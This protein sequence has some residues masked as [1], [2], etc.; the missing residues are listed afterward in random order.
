MGKIDIIPV[1]LYYEII[2]YN[3]SILCK[4]FLLNKHYHDMLSNKIITQY[5]TCCRYIADTVYSKYYQSIVCLKITLTTKKMVDDLVNSKFMS[6]CSDLRDIEMNQWD[7][8]EGSELLV[9]K[10]LRMKKI[11]SIAFECMCFY[12]MSLINFGNF[13]KL[14][15]FEYTSCNFITND[16]L[17]NLPAVE[18]LKISECNFHKKSDVFGNDKINFR[19]NINL[20]YLTL[21]SCILSD[22]TFKQ[23]SNTNLIFLSVIGKI[24][25]DIL[26]YFPRLKQLMFPFEYMLRKN[27]KHINNMKSL[28]F[29]NIW[30]ISERN[31]K[32]LKKSIT[33]SVNDELDI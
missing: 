13:K 14:K 11:E 26:Q 5:I 17:K 22:K 16:I 3:E 6:D 15:T 18:K 8:I 32:M 1:E 9:N 24:S 23:F 20:K 19:K 7:L 4:L 27:V 21:D 10:L 25:Y 31:S 12:D 30:N 28:E 29:L 33:I 2:S